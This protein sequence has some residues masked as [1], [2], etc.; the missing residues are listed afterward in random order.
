MF[1]SLVVAFIAFPENSD[2]ILSHHNMNDISIETSGSLGLY[3]DGKC[4]KTNGNET[5][6]SDEYQEWCSNI[7]ADE[8]DPAKNPYIQY[9][10][11]GKQLKIAK[12]SIRNGCCRYECC[13]VDDSYIAGNSCCCSPYSY[14]LQAS[15]DNKTWRVIHKVESDKYFYFCATK[16]YELPEKTQPFKYFRFVLDESW[17]HCPKCMQINQIEFY[18]EEVNSDYVL[19]NDNSDDDESISIIGRVNK[20][21]E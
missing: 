14:S 4:H 21:N 13:C 2:A 15:N 7:A 10:I 5:L 19:S 11:K 18:G 1:F 20:N 12:Y 3:Y 8:K 9:S 16:T 6:I 17:P